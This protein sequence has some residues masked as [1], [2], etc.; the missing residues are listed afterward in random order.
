MAVGDELYIP[1]SDRKE[2]ALLK[3]AFSLAKQRYSAIDPLVAEQIECKTS[4]TDARLWF[5]LRKRKPIPIVAFKKDGITGKV[6]A[7]L[8]P[9]TE[10][11]RQIRLMIEDGLSLNEI[12]NFFP[13]LKE[14][15]IA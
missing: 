13:D 12:K 15:E 1:V 7:V 5:V 8:P 10:R 9:N 2:L 3:R 4:T 6:T 14:E 11:R